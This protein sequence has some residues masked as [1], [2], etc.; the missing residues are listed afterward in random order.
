MN[1]EEAWVLIGG[2]PATVQVELRDH[3]RTCS[4]CLNLRA[5][6]LTFEV[7][8]RQALELEVSPLT[9]RLLS[10]DSAVT[11]EIAT[12]TPPLWKRALR[13]PARRGKWS[14]GIGLAAAVLMGLALWINRPHE[15]LAS[16]VIRHIEGE[17][18]SWTKTQ[19][20]AA[21]ALDPILRK[22]GIAV[23]PGTAPVVVYASS[24]DF[25]GYPMPHLVV[26]TGHGPGT[27]LVLT[28][29]TVRTSE[30]FESD[31][32]RGLLVPVG[33][34][35]VAI[36]SHSTIAPDE[37]AREVLQALELV[38]PPRLADATLSTGGPGRQSARY[39]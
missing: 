25:K 35:S 28:H 30:H 11:R 14:V 31:G 12:R 19:P 21:S 34:G 4:D 36:V 24:C 27:V 23:R 7:R 39:E 26:R 18:D 1:C 10:G 29:M 17:P 33:E 20:V 2:D 37:A 6:T 22:S 5:R 32:Y 38:T 8:L 13:K 16:E 9:P 15:A 3:L